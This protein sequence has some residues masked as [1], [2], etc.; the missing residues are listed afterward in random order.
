[1]RST[2]HIAD[3]RLYECFL[4]DQGGEPIDPSAAVHMAECASCADRYAELGRFLSVLRAEA[5]VE[6]DE[7][8]TPERLQQQQQQ[9]LRR[10]EHIS[11][12][13]KV[14]SFPGRVSRHIVATSVRIAPRWLAASAAAGLLVGVAVGAMYPGVAQRD[15]DVAIARL[16]P[17]APR[18][19]PAPSLVAP[20]S[21]P[22]AAVDDDDFL[23]DLEF[24]LARPQTRELQP[25]D[26]LTPHAREVISR[27]R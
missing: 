23:R 6:A 16:S 15:G 8:F 27:V 25:F 11:R 26:A 10:I 20:S 5:E 17:A 12:S 14:I 18:P 7:Q 2:R 21:P 9:I 13:A 3:D 22:K 4:A 24:A 19:M 1:M